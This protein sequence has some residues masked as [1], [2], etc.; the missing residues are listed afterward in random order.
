MIVRR[1]RGATLRLLLAAALLAFATGPGLAQSAQVPVGRLSDGARV[2]L[3]PSAGGYGLEV[4]E[5]GQSRLLRPAPVRLE[6]FHS[7]ADI[8]TVDIPY[9]SA[10]KQGSDIVATAEAHDGGAT[11]HIEDRYSVAGPVLSVSRSVQVEGDSPGT[12]FL[13]GLMFGV[14]AAHFDAVSYFAP[15]VLYR[16]PGQNNT[17]GPSG[18]AAFAARNFAIREDA[19]PAPLLGLSFAD[20]SSVTLLDVAPTGET[21]EEDTRAARPTVLID[22]RFGFGAFGSREDA[23]GN[24]EFGYWFPGGVTDPKAAGGQLRRRYHPLANGLT[25]H[26]RLALRFGQKESFPEFDHDAW[27]WAF[28]VLKPQ[29]TALDIDMVRRVLF[30]HLADRVTTIGGRTGIPWIFQVTNGENWHRPDD[31]RAAMG[32]VGLELF[33][34]GYWRR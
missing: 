23:N 2:F 14:P 25:Q 10:T 8:R 11:V 5:K 33:C 17:R 28:D 4:A 7:E 3:S 26:Y 13:T 32:F 22:R 12:G 20:Q 24:L 27:R 29:L 1:S 30:D 21:T 31:M 15:G 9:G 34:L 16:G 6:F 18:S 19:L